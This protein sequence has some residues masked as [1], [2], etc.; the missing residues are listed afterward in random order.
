MKDQYTTS[1]EICAQNQQNDPFVQQNKV[2]LPD[3]LDL[4]LQRKV[5]H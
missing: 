5:N 1:E 4:R 3:L 2:L